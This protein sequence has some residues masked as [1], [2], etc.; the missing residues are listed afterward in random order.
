MLYNF[1][2]EPTECSPSGMT[3]DSEDKLWIACS[4]WVLIKEDSRD[5][6]DYPINLRDFE[7]Y[8]TGKVSY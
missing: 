4:L 6:E 8:S 7:D 2:D 1:T 3:I 5:D